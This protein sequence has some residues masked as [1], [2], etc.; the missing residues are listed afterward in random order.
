MRVNH[1]EVLFYSEGYPNWITIKYRDKVVL[2]T[3]HP[4]ELEDLE[5]ALSRVRAELKRIE[6]AKRERNG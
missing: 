5:Y 4:L 3:L 1:F 2:E 6:E